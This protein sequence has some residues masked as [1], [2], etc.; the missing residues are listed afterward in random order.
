[1]WIGTPSSRY[2]RAVASRGERSVVRPSEKTT[3]QRQSLRNG[4]K[5]L[6]SPPQPSFVSER[7]R[8]PFRLGGCRKV[9]AERVTL[10]RGPPF[11][12]TDARRVESSCGWL[13]NGS[14]A[15][16]GSCSATGRAETRPTAAGRGASC[17]LTRVG[18]SRITKTTPIA[19][20]RNSAMLCCVHFWHAEAKFDTASKATRAPADHQKTSS[21]RSYDHSMFL[22]RMVVQEWTAAGRRF[23]YRRSW[24]S[25]R[26][27]SSTIAL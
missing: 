21:W 27:E 18:L 12:G 2:A 25:S 17:A 9:S 11:G 14:S 19:A 7:S 3:R 26:E 4:R 10:D 24:E 8:V 1:M 5:L 13:P 15:I 6:E 20:S 22:S 23:L 16:R